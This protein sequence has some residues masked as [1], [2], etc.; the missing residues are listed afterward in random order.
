MPSLAAD[1]AQDVRY[2]A[3]QLRRAPLFAL[4]IVGTVALAV[5]AATVMCSV[6]R[7]TLLHPLPYPHAEHLLE[8]GDT[9]LRGFETNGL[10]ALLRTDDLAHL[11]RDGR[12]VFPS[13]GFFYADDSTLTLPGAAPLRV[14]A[15]AVS[16]TF[17]PTL[18]APALLGRTLGPAD[19]VPNGPQLVVLSYRLWQS[20]FAGDPH[21]L[22]RTVRL[23]ADQ[24]TVVGVMSPQFAI[25]A[26]A[27][28]WHPGHIFPASF[29]GYRGDG[30][31]FL[32]VIARLDPAISLPTARA[33]TAE[34]AGRLARAYPETDA[35]WGFTLTDLRTGLFGQ[36]RRALDLLTAAVLLV[37]LAAIV[38]I[39]GL[40]LSRNAA[41]QGE[42][43]V[44]VALGIGRVRLARLLAVETLTPVLA[45]GITGVALAAAV[46]R[47]LVAHLP[48]ALFLVDR[49]HMDA[50]TVALALAITLVMGL[51]TA[52]APILQGARL[53]TAAPVAAGR[54]V[55]GRARTLGRGLSALQIALALVLLT[56][57]SAVLLNLYHLLTTPL[58]F[59]RTHL[60]TFSVD[61]PWAADPAKSHRLYAQLE[62]RFADL[63][64]VESAG[65]ITALPFADFSL[66][67]HF[68]IA[69]QPATANHDT[70]V[71]EANTFSPGY[72]HTLR[73]PLLAGRTFT[74]R[75]VEPGAPRV[76]VI[77]QTL[78]NRYF[79]GVDAVGKHLQTSSAD[80]HVAP[81]SDRDLV[82]AGEIIGITGDT[83][84]TGGPIDRAVQPEVDSPED[85]GWPHMQFAL[86]LRDNPSS[87][88]GEP[89][90][91]AAFQA[92]IRHLVTGL[93]ATASPGHFST[94]SATLGRALAQPRLNAA[95]L[96]AFA[97]LALLLVV[98]GVYGLVAFDVAGRTRELAV[99]LALG[100]TRAGV[101][102]LVLQEAA[103]ILAVGLAVGLA[104]SFAASRLLTALF[105]EAG[106]PPS[107]LLLLA[108]S[109]LLA[110]AVLLATL[111]PARRASMVDPMEALRSE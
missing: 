100:A 97:T 111:I 58:G 59:D 4:V 7:A 93:D 104:A 66:R 54:S 67:R 99:R 34:L 69:G 83:H 77:N 10:M 35:A 78:A 62:Q 11:T 6:L 41:R 19:D 110:A 56:L 32:E 50:P 39:A 9:N 64:G 95:L 85:G 8:A 63:P 72:L 76:L 87:P 53:R 26:A 102:R 94:L 70:V 2:T 47:L 15:A 81:G 23:G 105:F 36:Y 84:G 12:T 109:V 92:S 33:A 55:V 82:D 103:R 90:P 37:L 60:E 13:L 88:P 91:D 68:D 106:H 1:L 65:A 101:L 107:P 24:A 30:S 73:I 22:G 74:P 43:S 48:P 21:V 44:R 14:P 80:L 49:P 38:N 5:G 52:A 3:R 28:L 40:Q 46:L 98:L 89:T 31:R 20:A 75:D 25:P 86:R 17:F 51:L 45:G 57:S 18:A 96:T 16:G 108:A 29:R 79:H 42:L 71:A 61:L 27:D